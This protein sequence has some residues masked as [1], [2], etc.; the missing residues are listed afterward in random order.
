[1]S[2][3]H[4]ALKPFYQRRMRRDYRPPKMPMGYCS[5]GRIF[6]IAMMYWSGHAFGHCPNCSEIMLAYESCSGAITVKECAGDVGPS[7]N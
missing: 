3:F 4:V 6:N 2:E 7:G 5:C 1:M